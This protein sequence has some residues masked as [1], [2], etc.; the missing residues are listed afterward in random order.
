MPLPF[1]KTTFVS[2]MSVLTFLFY[3]LHIFITFIPVY[4][5]FVTNANGTSETEI[6][7]S[8]DFKELSQLQQGKPKE[9]HVK[10]LDTKDII[11]NPKSTQIHYHKGTIT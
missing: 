6:H 4:L 3:R 8:T 9:M 10:L 5:I 11:L 1:L 2:F 7:K